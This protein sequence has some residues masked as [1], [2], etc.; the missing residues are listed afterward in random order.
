MCWHLLEEV[1]RLNKKLDWPADFKANL[2]N[3]LQ[4]P[5]IGISSDN[6]SS[7]VHK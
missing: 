4:N 5:I 1:R 3:S 2:I 7:T 6:W